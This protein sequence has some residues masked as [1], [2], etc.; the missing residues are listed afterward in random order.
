M[1]YENIFLYFFLLLIGEGHSIYIRNLPLNLTVPQL[2]A[3]FKKFGPIKQGG[4]Q[5]RSNK[6]G[7]I[8]FTRT[9]L[10]PIGLVVICMFS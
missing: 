9:M 8:Y 1:P 5:V 6:V 4:V 7:F 10:C 2:E 3:N